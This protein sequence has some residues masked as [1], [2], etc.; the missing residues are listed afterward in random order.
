MI[1]AQFENL[2]P[3][4]HASFIVNAFTL[5]KFDVPY[6][7]HPQYELTLIVKGNG[8]R[9]VGK[10]MAG[11]DSGDLVFLGSDL[12][13]SWKSEN[14]ARTEA[15][16]SVVVQ[17]EKNFLGPEFFDKPELAEINNLL[18]LSACG[19]QF[20]HDGAAAAGEKMKLLAAQ[21][22]AFR[23]MTMLLEI[24]YDLAKSGDY[25]LLDP[26][27]T[28]AQ[29]HNSHKERVNAALGYIVDNFRNDIVLN[30][31]ASLA[32][33]SPNAFCK[34]FK[35]MTNKTFVE[36]VIDYRISFAVQQLIATDKTVSEIALESGF[37]DISH[38]YK[39][40][41]KRMNMSP[42]N[43]RNSFQKSL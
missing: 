40:F 26:D 16:Q 6:H 23:K 7:F 32:N 43:Y 2:Y 39:L 10:N 29:Q 4:S 8:K 18:K 11:F 24:L 22:N 19:I 42:L 3:D 5:D 27:A 36:T 41:K 17:F 1:K 12:P 37:G 35:K 31:V 20:I 15:V 30:K 14:T 33:M 21:E 25:V 9:F 28:I 13:H 38:F 34:Y